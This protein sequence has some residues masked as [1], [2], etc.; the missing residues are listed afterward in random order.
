[1]VSLLLLVWLGFKLGK[2]HSKSLLTLGSHW[3]VGL[4]EKERQRR[5]FIRD[6]TC[7][8]KRQGRSVWGTGQATGMLIGSE[9][10]Q[11]SEVTHKRHT[12]IQPVVSELV[13]VSCVSLWECDD[14]QSVAQF[15]HLWVFVWRALRWRYRTICLISLHVHHV[16]IFVYANPEAHSYQPCR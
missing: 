9:Q 2:S 12:N 4:S 10:K 16:N 13:W 5:T 7:M 1:M 14:L 15:S 11:N 8:D 3:S 6:K